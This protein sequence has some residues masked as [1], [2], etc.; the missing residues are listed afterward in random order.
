MEFEQVFDDLE[1]K[2]G[3]KGIILIVGALVLLFIYNY[4]KQTTADGETSVV[5]ISSYPD[6]VTNANVI[7][8]TLQDSID[9]SEKNIIDAVGET[10]TMISDNMSDGFSVTNDNLESS[11]EYTNS[12]LQSGFENTNDNISNLHSS[13]LDNFEATND[14]INSGFEAQKDLLNMEFDTII[15]GIND[16]QSG[17]NNAV[18][19]TEQI[20]DS[21]SSLQGSISSSN[22]SV[23]STN[24]TTSSTTKKTNTTTSKSNKSTTTYYSYKTKSGLNTSTSIVDALKAIG[25]DSS[26]SNRSAIAKANGIS[27]YTGSYSQNV[28]LLKKLKSGTL[29]KV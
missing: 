11:F 17:L 21:I 1:K 15:G 25:V 5:A 19:N 3:S 16:I 29:K 4:S 2:V 22:N 23:S 12:L 18:N 24:K 6:A 8:D 14:Y 13:M 7:I 27:N 26:M 28:S 9:Y 20:K 10:G